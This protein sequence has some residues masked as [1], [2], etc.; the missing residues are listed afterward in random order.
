M[1]GAERVVGRRGRGPSASSRANVWVVLGLARVEA[2]V[3]EHDER[4][5]PAAARAAAPRPGASRTPG[6]GPSAGRGASRRRTSSAPRSSRSSSVGS[7]ARIR[8]SSATRPSSSGTFR[9]ART[10]TRLPDDVGV[11]DRPRPTHSTG[12]PTGM[13]R[14]LLDDVGEAA[15]VAPLVVVPADH[16]DHAPVRHRRERRPRSASAG[17]R[18]CRTRRSRRRCTA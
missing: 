7:A 17:C 6:R 3:L 8:V 9:S 14:D 5:R 15:A 11:A 12:A 16:L 13:P 18:R 2:R 1:R 10:S 4:A